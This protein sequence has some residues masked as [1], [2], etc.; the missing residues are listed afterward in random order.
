MA[1]AIGLHNLV[2]KTLNNK[3]W[4]KYTEQ[5][6]NGIVEIL[7]SPKLRINKQT[8]IGVAKS[9]AKTINKN[10]NNGYKN[11]GDVAYA[12]FNF[13]GWGIVE[14]SPTNKQLDLIN[15]QDEA[16]I[17]EL[18]RQVDLE[19]QQKEFDRLAKEGNV[20]I[21][22]EGDVVS[23]DDLKYQKLTAQ[24]KAKTIE[25]VTK[26]HRSITALKDLAAK[27]AWRIGGKVEFVNNSSLDYKGFAKGL[28]AT[29]NEAW[30]DSSTIFHEA[31]GHPI[32]GALKA[33]SKQKES[34]SLQE[35]LDKN[36]I[37]KKCN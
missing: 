36:I 13:N 6:N 34:V 17:A 7:N 31:L 16:E 19:N 9:T 18:Q 10:V 22:E 4:F 26:E 3:P 28:N 21:N 8:S 2:R 15:A 1:C 35:M 29:Y 33:L 32:I 30:M 23:K 20:Y 37:E 27:L 12:R 24:E 5:G 11:V 14:I 25:Q